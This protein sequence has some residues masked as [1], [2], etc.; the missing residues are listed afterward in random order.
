MDRLARAE[1]R[2]AHPQ[3]GRSGLPRDAFVRQDLVAGDEPHV[4]ARRCGGLEVDPIGVEADVHGE[5]RE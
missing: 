1:A 4:L 5:V 3:L 2:H